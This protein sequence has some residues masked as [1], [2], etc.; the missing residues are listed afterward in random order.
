MVAIFRAVRLDNYRGITVSST[1]GK[2]FD[3]VMLS[4]IIVVQSKQNTSQ[5]GLTNKNLYFSPR[6][7]QKRHSM[8][9]IIRLVCVNSIIGA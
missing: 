1:L 7:T 3:I 8:L 4:Y 2:I 5:S 6:Q 9:L